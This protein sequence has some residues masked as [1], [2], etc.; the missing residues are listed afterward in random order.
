M[1]AALSSLSWT[2]SLNALSCGLFLLC[3]FG[4]VAARQVRGCLE[5]F[6]AQSAFLAASA[7]LLGLQPFLWHLFVVGALTVLTKILLIPWLL[8]RMLHEALHTRREIDQRINIPTSL[9]IGLALAVFAYVLTAPLL[10]AGDGEV[11]RTNLPIGL[12]AVLLGAYTLAVRREA[13]PSLFGLLSMES[14][15]LLAGIAIAPD[16]PL[17][18]ELVGAFDVLILAFIVGLFTRAIHRH[19]GSTDVGGLASL[20]EEPSP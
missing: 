8:G 6:I 16:M 10:P 3:A 11:A 2:V 14:G 9:L 7:F 20:R 19:I 15:A 18:A 1:D 5:F 13:M 4:M 17:I 12:A